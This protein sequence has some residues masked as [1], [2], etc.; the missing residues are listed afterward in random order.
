[1]WY[2]LNY[3]VIVLYIITLLLRQRYWCVVE[4][5]YLQRSSVR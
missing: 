1:M 4:H 5:Y 2:G 3:K